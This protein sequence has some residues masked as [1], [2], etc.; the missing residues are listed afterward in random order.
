MAVVWSVCKGKMTCEP[1]EVK[2]DEQEGGPPVEVKKGHGGCGHH[3]PQI[4]KEG[5][6]LFFNYKKQNDDEES[7]PTV[8]E[9]RQVSAQDVFSVFRKI[10]TT[11]L[12]MLGLSEAYARP[13]WM[14]LTVLPVPPPPVRPSISVDGGVRRSEDD[15]TY[16]LAEI[17][18]ASGNVRRSEQ[19]GAPPHIVSEYEQLL[20]YHVATYM[21]NDI[22]GVPQAMQKSG[23]PIKAIRARLKGKEGRLRGNLMGKRVDFSAR[24]VITGDPNLQLDQ[25]GVPRSIAMTLTY[26]ERVTRYNIQYLTELVR[27]G[28]QEYPGARYVIRDTGERIDLKYNKRSDSLLQFGWIVERHLKDGDYV[29]FNRQPSL[30]KMSMMSHRVKIMPY[31]TF[32]LNLSVTPPYNADFDGDEMNLHVPQSEETRAELSQIAWVPR[33]I[34]SPQ[35]NKPVMG[36][37]QDTLCGIRKFTLRD[38]FVDWIQVQNLLLWLP[39]W[40]GIV[41]TPTILKPKPLWT[42]KQLLSMCIPRGINVLRLPESRSHNPPADDGMMI[43]NGEIIFGVVDKKTVG[44][45][46][47]G[48]VHV[49]FREKGPEICRDLFS[50][51]QMIV[52]FWLFHNGFSIGIGDT[53]A[54]NQTMQGVSEAI[55]SAK[56]KV[57]KLIEDASNDRLKAEPGMTIRESFESHVNMHLNKARDTAGKMA[58]ESLKDSNNVKQMVVAGS[59]GSFINIAQM[60]VAV[61]Q[62]SVE[63]KRIPFGFRHRSLPHFTKDDFSPESRGFVE[64]SYLRGL[65]P[66]EFFFHAMAG[67]E[68]LIDTAIKTA[69]TGYI[70]RRLVKALEDVMVCYDGTVRNSLGDILQFTYG[71]DGIDGGFI[72]RQSVATYH[73]SNQAFERKYR[74]DVTDP[75]LGFAH[76]VLQPGLEDHSLE[77]QMKL[78]AEWEELRRDRKLLREFIF[79]YSDPG[80]DRYM[81]VNVRRV[82]QNAQQIFH[83]DRREASDLHPGEIYDKLRELMS[84]LIVVRGDDELSLEAQNNATMMFKMHL[85]ATFATK[86][87]LEEYHLTKQAF[88]WVLGEIE[89]RFNQSLVQPGEMCG[90]LAAQSIGEPAT[91]MTLNTF[92][93]AGVSSKNVTLGVPRLKEIINVATNIKTPILT[94]YLQD[95]IAREE[96]GVL[97]KAVQTEL[98]FTTLRTITSTVEI[99]YDPEPTTTVIEEDKDFVDAFFAIPDPEIEAKLHVLSPWVLRLELD[100]SKMLDRKLEMA[101]VA[102]KIGEKFTSDLFIIWS[103]DNSEKLIIRCRIVHTPEKMEAMSDFSDDLFLRQLE[104]TLLNTVDLRGVPGVDRVF[105]VKKDKVITRPDGTLQ[106]KALTDA[107]REW[108]L[109]TDGVNLKKVLAVDGVDF[110]RTTS[111]SC[112]E[113]FSVLGIEAARASLLREL[114]GVIEFDGSYVNYRHLAILV[115]LMTNKGNL[116]AI[117]R[118]GINR[119]DTGALMRCSFEET[120]EILMDAAS[121]GEKDDCRGIAENV[122]FGQIAPMGTGSFDVALDMEMLKDVMVESTVPIPHMMGSVMDGAAT[123]GGVMTPYDNNSPMP[124]ELK[125]DHQAAFSPLHMNGTDDA[126]SF[127]WQGYAPSPM[128]PASGGMSPHG[129]S[130]SSPRHYSPTS[131]NITA[132]SPYHHMAGATSPFS[133]MQQSPWFDRTRASATSPAYSPGMTSPGYSPTSP[134]YSPTSPGYSPTS[135]VYSPTSPKYSPT[136]PKYSPTSPRY[137]PTSPKYSP[138]SP[139]YSPTSPTYSPTSPHYSPTSPKY[140][141]TSPRY[142]PTSPKYSPTSPRYSPTSPQYSPTS[143]ARPA[144]MSPASPRYSP[145]SPAYAPKSPQYSPA[146]PQYSPTSPQWSGNTSQGSTQGNSGSTQYKSSPS[147]E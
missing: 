96:T 35:A 117:T 112:T 109:E 33:Q 102:S 122:M 42:G 83:I 34:V 25:V 94:V 12:E 78:D 144:G 8:Q 31:S 111:N 118:H 3:Q 23:R 80:A 18:R 84:R 129:Y 125:V 101:Y 69:E 70:Q 145:T 86:P 63:G 51:L 121:L 72:E 77:L 40:D 37:V 17:I 1:D 143:P 59:K 87:V 71:E 123:P 30:H 58:Q 90:T 50:G 99:H 120:V 54:D 116:T 130:P 39:G 132:M 135:P 88:E 64:N 9:K 138:T 27:R 139:R 43:E 38:T 13:D 48:L 4:R 104:V 74:V 19:E 100:R 7:R 2:E 131:P 28:P 36:I 67:R 89:T 41:P 137:S 21:D 20:Q 110:R 49:V 6:K 68:G 106:N 29:L 56:Q 22:A 115:D 45:T 105:L 108:V 52:N 128:R 126:P 95:E 65:T 60:S 15:L 16:K 10:S 147:W 26:P 92:H 140:S 47:G 11:D 75:K 136:S 113:I 142:S 44:A 57:Q 73:L 14:I 5:L 93:Y 146:S 76:G 85:R 98:A 124:Y 79:R 53:I 141:P 62:Q 32:R 91:Q 119:A 55:L 66:S 24:T 114:R 81:P 61:G 127:D 103:E 82:I 134:R 46:Q 133:P 97:A 107:E